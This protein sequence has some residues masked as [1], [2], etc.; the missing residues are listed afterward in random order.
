MRPDIKINDISMMGLGWLRET[1]SFP[2]PKAQSNTIVVPGRN[3][4]IRYT[5]ALGKLSF[6]PRT[7]QMQFSMLG[8]REKYN[9]MVSKVANQFQGVLSKVITS[10]EPNLY[11][12]GTINVAQSYDPLTGKGV[13]EISCEDGDSYRYYIEETEVSVTGGG[14]VILE[15]DY[16]PVIP[17][18]I[19]SA[20][21]TLS[22]KVGSDSIIKTVSAGTWTFPEMELVHGENTVSITGD[23]TTTF[24]YREGCL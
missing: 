19:T 1:V 13:A 14:K 21:T 24:R 18:V 11:I 17:S 22:W 8:S 5:E 15:N 10:E 16:M 6:E 7:F 23:G 20:D 12:V 4:P 3:S 9:E 2:T